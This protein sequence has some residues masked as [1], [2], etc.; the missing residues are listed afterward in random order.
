MLHHC[1]K[2]TDESAFTSIVLVHK[3][4]KAEAISTHDEGEYKQVGSRL[5]KHLSVASL[6]AYENLS[7]ADTSDD[8]WLVPNVLLDSANI[9]SYFS[10]NILA[11][12]TKHWYES[13]YI[14]D[15]KHKK[16]INQYCT[17]SWELV[18]K[19]ANY[20]VIVCIL[21]VMVL[22]DYD[23]IEVMTAANI[24]LFNTAYPKIF[25]LWKSFARK[26]S[27]RDSL[28]M[29]DTLKSTETL[30]YV[31]ATRNMVEMAPVQQ[32]MATGGIGSLTHS[33]RHK[34]LISNINVSTLEEV[35]VKYEQAMSD[36]FK[37][38]DEEQKLKNIGG[39][40]FIEN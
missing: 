4:A 28:R 11:K 6:F 26:T 27:D 21:T 31:Q 5:M 2:A 24:P 34:S 22:H 1:G 8:E 10:V 13:W 33:F 15:R 29:T 3:I 20:I 18:W 9:F 12:A 37:I 36:I 39:Q 23:I 35:E 7:N 19:A 40:Y 32:K 16:S 30:E 14:R 17:A 25:S 38:K